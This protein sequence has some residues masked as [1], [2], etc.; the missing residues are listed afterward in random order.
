MQFIAKN[1]AG[2]YS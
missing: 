1:A 2:M